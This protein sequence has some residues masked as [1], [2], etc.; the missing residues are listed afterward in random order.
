MLKKFFF[1]LQSI[2][3]H[4][5]F[6][7][8]RVIKFFL[9][10]DKMFRDGISDI[11]QIKFF[12]TCKIEIES[13]KL[14][15]YGRSCNTSYA[16]SIFSKV[17]ITSEVLQYH[18][19][20]YFLLTITRHFQLRIDFADLILHSKVPKVSDFQNKWPRKYTTEHAF[21]IEIPG[22]YVASRRA[23]S[24]MNHRRID[25]H[26]FVCHTS[27]PILSLPIRYKCFWT[28]EVRGWLRKYNSSSIVFPSHFLAYC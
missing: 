7:M 4:S 13:K 21:W 12:T 10:L 8:L 22:L 27:D 17:R 25:L 23:G 16:K 5:E 11:I 2:I 28:V 3:F 1:Y 24:I 20:A 19:A 26:C 9:F 14:Y 15:E 18:I 6:V